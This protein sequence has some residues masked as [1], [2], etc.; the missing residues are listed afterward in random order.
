MKEVKIVQF[1]CIVRDLDKAMKDYYEILGIGPWDV[2][3]L[4]D[5]E[6]KWYLYGKRM[7]KFKLLLGLAMVGDCQYE[8]LQYVY[9]PGLINDFLEKKGR[10]Y[11]GFHHIKQYMSDEEMA[12]AIEK[13]K[14]MGLKITHEAWFSEDHTAYVDVSEIFGIEYEIGNCGKIRPPDRRYPADLK[15]ESAEDRLYDITAKYK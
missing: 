12:K 10:N 15:G 4:T 14:S 6:C 1:C 5:K 7:E 9:G 8:L 2:W 13:W 11:Q 3:E